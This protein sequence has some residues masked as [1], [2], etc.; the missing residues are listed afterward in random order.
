MVM[1]R[2]REHEVATVP[3]KD[4]ARLAR[5]RLPFSDSIKSVDCTLD[6]LNNCGVERV[7]RVESFAEQRGIRVRSTAIASG[8]TNIVQRSIIRQQDSHRG[9]EELIQLSVP[10][11]PG[12]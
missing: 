6:Q 10:S 7:E 11:F 1:S 3:H 2:Y 9:L 8:A 5:P 12:R 4:G